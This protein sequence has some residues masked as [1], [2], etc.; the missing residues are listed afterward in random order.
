LGLTVWAINL[1]QAI[2]YLTGG[3]MN[4][5]LG[6]LSVMVMVFTLAISIH[7]LHYFEASHANDDPLRAALRLAGKPCGLATLTT[8]IGALSLTVSDIAPIKQFGYAA[9]LGSLVALFAG[10]GLMPA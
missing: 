4:F 8:V 5:I 3:E 9:S 6:A 2:I 7:V 10:L 1:T